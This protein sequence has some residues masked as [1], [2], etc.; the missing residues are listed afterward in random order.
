MKRVFIFFLLLFIG[1]GD[2]EEVTI[3]GAD[4]FI[5][6]GW[7]E[8]AAGNYSD[9]IKKFQKALEETPDNSEAYNGVGWSMARLSQLADS[10]D[11]FKKA[12][13]K[14]ST[15]VDAYAGL[16]GVYFASEDYERAV[17]S[18][19]SALL[20]NPQYVSH[21]DEIKAYDVRV[22]MAECYYIVG[23]YTE[24]VAQ[25]DLIGGAGMNLDPSSST[26]QA[27][28]ISVI[29]ELSGENVLASLGG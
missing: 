27:D 28:L 4:E 6:E 24:A 23:N 29:D 17:A 3:P 26:Y 22:L 11:S 5:D 21:H 18:A 12:T 7:K 1:C 2:K 8:Y 15:N 10:I 16:A 25:I 9:A 14:D 13:E 20:L 19:K